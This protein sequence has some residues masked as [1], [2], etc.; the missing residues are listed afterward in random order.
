MKCAWKLVKL[1]KGQ[2]MAAPSAK[3]K[4]GDP[5]P[6]GGFELHVA[7]D[8]TGTVFGVNDQGQVDISAIATLAASS[9]DTGIVTVSVTGGMTFKETGVKEGDATVKFDATWNDGSIG[10]FGVDDPVHVVK[11]PPGPV[12]GLIVTHDPPVSR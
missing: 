5:L 12:T 3:A 8:G 7:E 11:A 2:K 4:K 1:S 10:P 6:S 9:S